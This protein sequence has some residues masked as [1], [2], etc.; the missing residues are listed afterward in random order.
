VNAFVTL[1]ARN[2]LDRSRLHAFV[3]ELED[4]AKPSLAGH[5]RL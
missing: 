2:K 1:T 3:A 5:E 4:Q